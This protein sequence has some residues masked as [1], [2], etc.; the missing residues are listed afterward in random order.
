MADTYPVRAWEDSVPTKGWDDFAQNQL[1][2][3]QPTN[4]TAFAQQQDDLARNQYNE[5]FEYQPGYA[6]AQGQTGADFWKGG[7]RGVGELAAGALQ[8]STPG[9]VE[10]LFSRFTGQPTSAERVLGVL[11]DAPT[12]DIGKLGEVGAKIAG[13]LPLG[14]AGGPG[15]GV[16][17]LAGRVGLETARGAA[18]GAMGQ[19]ENPMVGAAAGGLL[20]GGSQTVGEGLAALAPAMVK[21]MQRLYPVR[22]VMESA[23]ARQGVVPELV[24]R[25]LLEEGAWTGAGLRQATGQRFDQ[26][27]RDITNLVASS[28]MTTAMESILPQQGRLQIAFKLLD[29]PSVASR[30]PTLV[31]AVTGRGGQVGAVGTQALKEELGAFVRL[32]GLEPEIA[33]LARTGAASA[34]D[35]ME[36]GI[37]GYGGAMAESQ[38][39]RFAQEASRQM[40][41][42]AARVAG[43]TA[44]AAAVG[45]AAS[46]LGWPVAAGVGAGMGYGSGGGIGESILLSLL[47]A[48]YRG[49]PRAAGLAGQ[50]T[51]LAET[52]VA[53]Y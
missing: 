45:T 14:M 30:F 46:T 13:T 37:P 29:D 24:A 42:L 36:Q 2:W 19:P 39:A 27:G 47:Q 34:R 43:N 17:S 20:G 53:S 40:N 16:G 18:L 31:S 23:T 21:A 22:K 9:M 15:L 11:P 5:N 50:A 25:D 32:A 12:T 35:A 41:P 38:A 28:P 7:A 3:E 10:S 51:P 26:A 49:G 48:L 1:Q 44:R 6:E 4:R 8:L 33:Q 52:A